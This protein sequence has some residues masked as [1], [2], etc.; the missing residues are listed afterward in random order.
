MLK[1]K[2]VADPRVKDDLR[3]ARIFLNNKR[4]GY[5]NKFLNEYKKELKRLSEYPNF[6]IRYDNIRCLPLKKF[7]YMIHYY[8]N[9]QEMIVHIYAVLSTNLDPDK[10]YVIE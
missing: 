2:V 4:K 9:L 5:G 3:E 6:Q 7:K 10:H 8:V 1:F